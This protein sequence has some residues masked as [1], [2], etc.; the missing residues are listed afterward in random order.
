MTTTGVR[1]A[2]RRGE[3]GWV[4]ERVVPTLMWARET[5]GFHTRIEAANY[6]SLLWPERDVVA[7]LLVDFI[8]ER[9]ELVGQHEQTLGPAQHAHVETK[10]VV[11]EFEG[12]VAVRLVPDPPAEHAHRYL[13]TLFFATWYDD[14]GHVQFSHESNRMT[15]DA[16]ESART[17]L[18]PG[19][20]V[21]P[22]IAFEFVLQNTYYG[23]GD[24]VS[25]VDLALLDFDGRVLASTGHAMAP[26]TSS[27]LGLEVF[28]DGAQ[29]AR[30]SVAVRVTGRHLNHPFTFI[31]HRNGDFNIH[32]F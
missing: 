26:R 5:T 17:F 18:S 27:V 31:H 10:S 30:G 1:P 21:R 24:I 12:T 9:G 6:Y 28:G 14:A 15:F 8:D 25:D 3:G 4:R 2:L 16:D 19:T 7:T 32:H 20:I 11:P 13:G 22:E 23:D 29:R